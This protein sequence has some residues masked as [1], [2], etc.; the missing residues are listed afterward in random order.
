MC[1]T[2]PMQVTACTQFAATC[3]AR[4]VERQISL[5]L[6]Q[7]EDIRVGDYVLVHL[8]EAIEKIDRAAF[9]EAWAAYDQIF[10][11]EAVARVTA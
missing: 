11:A 10:G 6:L 1:L 2:V 9:D 3:V 5:F 7:H 8:R 4:G